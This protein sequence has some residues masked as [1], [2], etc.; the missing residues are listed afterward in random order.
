[1]NAATLATPEGWT[2]RFALGEFAPWFGAPTPGKAT[3]AFSTTAGRY[4][5]LG[6]V[7]PPGPARD[8]AMAVLMANAGLFDDARLAA[9]LVLNDPESI[10][11]AS[12]HLPGVR[13]FLDADRTVTRLFGADEGQ[14][15]GSPYWLLLDPMLR[16]MAQAPWEETPAMFARL[17]KLPAVED[18]AG[19]PLHAPVLIVPR[20]FEP[21]LCRELIAYY[22]E[23]GGQPSGV[24]RQVGDRTVGVLDDFKRR[25]D[26]SIED[27]AFRNRIMARIYRRLIPEIARVFQFRATRIERYTVACYD[28]ADGGYFR[29][30]RDNTT[31]GTAHRRFACSINL[32]AEEFEGGDLRFPEF[33]RR[34]YRPPTGG[35]VVFSCSLQHE[36]TSVT[37]GRRYAYLPFLYD[38]E[39]AAIRE[40]NRASLTSPDEPAAEIGPATDMGA[41]PVIPGSQQRR[42][43]SGEFSG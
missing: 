38:E 20:V 41:A 34:T 11:S 8:A 36:A 31:L 33:G 18:Y 3:F 26:V 40:A 37:R 35:V 24:M 32:N 28:A 25:K 7:P 2:P 14:A 6:L 16:V 23:R 10:A 21:S 29:P 19:V 9:F 4:V 13:W 30:H 1:M 27:P 15:P 17:A 5:L 22:D 39:G 43:S 12:N 42:Q